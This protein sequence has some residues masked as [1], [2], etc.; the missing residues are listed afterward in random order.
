M[1]TGQQGILAIVVLAGF[2]ACGSGSSGPDRGD[3]ALADGASDS[4]RVDVDDG[5]AVQRLPT[6]VD[7]DFR[8]LLLRQDAYFQY[9]ALVLADPRIPEWEAEA[10]PMI[11]VAGAPQDLESPQ[12]VNPDIDCAGGCFTDP[13]M[14]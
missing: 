6:T 4:T 7:E 3:D 14:R 13:T 9:G 11:G 1:R 8:L 5:D 10:G 12:A 2:T